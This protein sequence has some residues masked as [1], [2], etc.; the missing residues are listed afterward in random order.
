MVLVGHWNGMVLARRRYDIGMVLVWYWYGIG[1]ALVLA[2]DLG[3]TVL[4]K[5]F[6]I[7]M[8]WV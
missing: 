1:M 3:D 8:V 5:S 7:V 4:I 6:G 2:R